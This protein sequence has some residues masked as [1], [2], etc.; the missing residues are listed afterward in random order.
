MKRF[1]LLIIL[2]SPLYCFC[3]NFNIPLNFIV[4][5][6]AQ[7]WIGKQWDF[8]YTQMKTPI[9]V[10][11]DGKVLKMNYKTGESFSNY[12]ILDYK[13]LENKKY[14]KIEGITYTLK[15]EEDGYINYIV[16]EKAINAFGYSITVYIPFR[17]NNGTIMSYFIYNVISD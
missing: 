4:E 7:A 16:I 17:G 6:E 1:F 5:E 11:F 2:F 12:T 8:S 9:N 15:Y 10:H 14:N 3:Q 13:K